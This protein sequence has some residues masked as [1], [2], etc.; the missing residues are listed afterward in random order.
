VLPA[1][2][3]PWDEEEE[4]LDEADLY[5]ELSVDELLS[6]AVRSGHVINE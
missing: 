4:E 3:D 1:D 2:P 6:R 5:A